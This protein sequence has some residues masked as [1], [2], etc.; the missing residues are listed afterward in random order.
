MSTDAENGK[1]SKSHSDHPIVRKRVASLKP[2][3]ENATLYDADDPEEIAMLAASI[4]GNGCA[5]LF[6]TR[7]NYIVSGHR[8][9]AAL[10][11]NG[12]VWIN[13]HVLDVRRDQMN[14]DEFIAL[15]R[16]HNRQ[17]HKSVA[18]QVRETLVDV[19][20]DQAY[21]N[22]RERRVKSIY[23]P[24][25]NG[26]ELVEIE[27]SKR[28]FN[29][30]AEKAEHV[31][32]I[33]QVVFVDLRDYWPLS[34]RGI[35][36]P[37]LNYPFLRNTR[38]QLPYRN[39]DHSYDATCELLTR[40]R[41]NGTIPWEAMDDF[42]R[43]FKGYRAFN[44]VGAFVQQEVENLFSGYWRKLLQTQSNHVET[45]VEKNT[46]YHMAVQV[47]GKYQIETSSGRGFNSI[48]PWHDL[49][50]RNRASGKEWLIV[51]VLSDFDPEGEMIPQVSGRTLRDDFGV[52]K[53]KI[54]KAGVTRAQIEQYQLPVQNFAKETSSNYDWFVRR[55][56][57]D[58]SVYELEALPPAQMLADLDR[59]IRSVIDTELFNAEVQR[60]REESAYLEA[61]RDRTVEALRGITD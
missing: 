51:I 54:I 26:I 29:I 61:L 37:L 17:R 4:K 43:P 27:G 1:L 59:V 21:A 42:T 46:V 39:D 44:D 40:L 7:D 57:G 33:K 30:S 32:N 45:V 14:R 34:A 23:A 52:D 3:P 6:I 10:L 50:V 24:E 41:L 19:D 48:D 22:L 35:H 28:R 56:N 58:T 15:L 47:T 2:S 49:Y 12:Q 55:N 11:L 13:C 5:A 60:E 31:R 53:L 38:L 18:E 36:Y 8:R 9:H 20:R 16:D 25:F